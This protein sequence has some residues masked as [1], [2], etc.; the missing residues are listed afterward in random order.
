[1]KMMEWKYT[2]GVQNPFRYRGYYY[3]NETGM[4]YLR[5]RYYDP[6]LRRFISADKYVIGTD[7]ILPNMYMCCGNNPVSN[8]S[9]RF[10]TS[11]GA[12]PITFYT[13]VSG[14]R[15]GKTNIETGISINAKV[16]NV[17]TSGSFSRSSVAITGK[18]GIGNSTLEM[19]IHYNLENASL[20]VD[21]G[22]S[23]SENNIESKTTV[24]VDVGI[25]ELVFAVVVTAAV[26]V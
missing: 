9:S 20:E 6:E 26:G 17:G 22:S 23:M 10:V 13:G 19:G 25:L 1:M 5:N 18:I 21:F 7:S 14:S 8:T 2:V 12:R 3:D 4:Y 16:A 24:S 15:L 11:G